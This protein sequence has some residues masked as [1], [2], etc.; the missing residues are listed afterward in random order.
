MADFRVFTPDH[1]EWFFQEKARYEVRDGGALR[2]VDPDNN[3]L[4]VFGP[5]G[6]LRVEDND[7]PRGREV[8]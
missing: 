4:V 3:R 2:V 6:W 5:A 1:S 7:P 8:T